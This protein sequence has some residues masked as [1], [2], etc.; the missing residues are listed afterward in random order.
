MITAVAY[1][2]PV[3]AIAFLSVDGSGN[4]IDNPAQGATGQPLIRLTPNA[5]DDGISIPR[6]ELSAVLPSARA[7]SNAVAQQ[8][9]LIANSRGAS[10]WLWQW[11]QFLDHDIDLS[12]SASPAEPFNIAVPVGDTHFD[13]LHTGT[14]EI[15]LNR[16]IYTE[17]GG[18]REQINEISAYIDASNVYGSDQVRADYLRAD[19]GTLAMQTGGNGEALLAFNDPMSPLPNATGGGGGNFFLA[20][21]VRTNEQI[22]LTAVHT[23]FSR[24]HN[25]LALDLKT[26]LDGG[27]AALV[28]ARNDVI[29]SGDID[30]E[31]DFIY[32]AARR[33]VAAQIQKITY[34]EFLPLLTGENL[35]A[36]YSG[37]DL[38]IDASISNE[39]STAAFRVGHTMLSPALLRFEL[40]GIGP[41]ASIALRD[42]FFNPDEVFDNGVDSLLLGLARQPAQAI[43]T[44]IVD[45]VRNFLFGPPGAGGF[46]LAALNIQRGRDHGLGSLNAVRTALGLAPYTDF[47]ELAGNDALLADAFA[48]LYGDINHVDLWSGGLAEKA[49]GQSML[50]ETFTRIIVDQ[51]ARLMLGDR[52]FYLNDLSTLALFDPNFSQLN[53][54]R[55]IRDNSAITAI[56]DNVFLADLSH[57]PEPAAAGLALLALALSGSVRRHAD[58]RAI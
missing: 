45:E 37:Y 54:A 5:Y 44:R 52:F 34:T 30:D 8:N 36:A 3:S 31:S 11:G 15:G 17:I 19:H 18:V 49:V 51:F 35:A 27:D 16:S 42:A 28:A 13:P 12:E 26:R 21:D 40:D 20:G 56:Q 53:L 10:D 24:E 2:G 25:R 29:G 41:A 43:D 22:G 7:V 55:I 48:S 1:A 23:L 4:N 6:G 32:A 33:V 39:F 14:R 9:D 50:G 46:D 47:S 38:S 58:A 57:V